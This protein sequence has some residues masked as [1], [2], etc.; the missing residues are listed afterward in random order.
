[1]SLTRRQLLKRTGLAALALVLGRPKVTPEP[2]PM[3]K[4]AWDGL[5]EPLMMDTGNSVWATT[6]PPGTVWVTADGPDKE[7]YT[8]LH[9]DN[10]S[11]LDPEVGRALMLSGK[12]NVVGTGLWGEPW[13]QGG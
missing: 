6:E 12:V 13:E 11:I 10:V 4:Q 7:R 2:N 5:A 1:M 8:W 9:G 3:L